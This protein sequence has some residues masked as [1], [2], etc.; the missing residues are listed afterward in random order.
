MDDNWNLAAMFVGVRWEGLPEAFNEKMIKV[1]D[2]KWFLKKFI[3]IQY[4]NLN[5]ANNAHKSA[6]AILEKYDLY[7]PDL[8]VQN[9]SFRESETLVEGLRDPKV[10]SKDKDKV[11]GKCKVK[12]KGRAKNLES[13][14]FEI[15]KELQE[16]SEFQYVNVEK[17]YLKFV[18]YLSSKGKRHKD[19]L[20]AFRNGV[21]S[22]WT[23]KEDMAE[24]QAKDP[25]KV[26]VIKVCFECDKNWSLPMDV[27]DCPDCSG[28]LENI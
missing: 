16:R 19:Y 7:S 25:A 24:K 15:R 3:E 2:D 27:N 10:G 11:R 6:I 1:S 18:D 21:R 28:P 8:G 13:I 4:P 23:D 5:P 22:S 20:A 12:E 14:T 17:Q 9:P 26:E